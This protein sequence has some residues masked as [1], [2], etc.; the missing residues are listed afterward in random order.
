[1]RR[2]LL[3]VIFIYFVFISFDEVK[4]DNSTRPVRVGCVDIDNFMTIDQNGDVSGY[5]A[6]YLNEIAKHTNWDYRYVPGTWV[7]CLKWL[8]EGKIDLL[9]PA[10]YSEERAEYF[11]YSGF[12]CSHDYVVLLTLASNEELFYEDYEGFDGIKVGMI[13]GNY[14]N[15]VFEQYA[16]KNN[17]KVYRNYYNSGDALN[18]ALTN[19]EVNAIVT[20]N[21]SFY[22]HQKVLAKIDT[23]PTYFITAKEKADLMEDLNKALSKINIENP[24]FEAGLFEKYFGQAQRQSIA[25]TKEELEFVNSSGEI[26]LYLSEDDRPMEWLN[27]QTGEFEGIYPDLIRLIGEQSGLNIHF[28]SADKEH[29]DWRQTKNGEA[30]MYISDRYASGN[31]SDSELIYTD[32][33]FENNNN[34]IGRKDK[35]IHLN[36]EIVLAI[37]RIYEGMQSNINGRYPEWKVITLSGIEKCIEAVVRGDADLALINPYT[38]QINDYMENHKDLEVIEQIDIYVPVR[39]GVSAKQPDILLSILNK[40]IY[41]INIRQKQQC[42]LDNTIRTEHITFEWMIHENPKQ[43]FIITI[44]G[45]SLLFA[46]IFLIYSN[47]LKAKQNKVLEEKNRLLY[48]ASIKERELRNENQ[49]DALTGIKNKKTIE[50]N[51]REY[52][53]QHDDGAMFIIDIDNFKN[54]NDTYGH[55]YGD[56]VLKEIGRVLQDSCRADDM[57]GRMGGDEF[58]MLLKNIDDYDVICKRAEEVGQRISDME[59]EDKTIKISSSIGVSIQSENKLTYYTM[60]SNADEALYKAKNSGKNKYVIYNNCKE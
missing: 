45:M 6:E 3:A 48:E 52:I 32:A 44:V 33:F 58:M 19:G 17:F 10:Q 21:M 55:Q 54:V 22:S 43:A 29:M 39:L 1:M 12:S 14:L 46:G 35:E 2:I 47:N 5:G 16:A 38:I 37:P 4:A 26:T 60:F 9:L 11:L 15:E 50:K 30:S 13:E 42:V 25:F 28:A 18:D 27:E 59:F 40:S 31:D 53:E 23:M 41:K 8:K 49:I 7:E 20:G 34:L 24:Y 51:C 56:I 57:A 36:E